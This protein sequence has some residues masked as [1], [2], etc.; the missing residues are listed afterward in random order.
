MSSTLFQSGF[1]NQQVWKI[2]AQFQHAFNFHICMPEA[3]VWLDEI[4]PVWKHRSMLSILHFCN[5]H[6]NANKSFL[7]SQFLA[8]MESVKHLF[9]ILKFI[10]SSECLMT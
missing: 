8:K 6:P 1:Q 4:T 3:S 10:W 2:A 5:K 9:M 7:G